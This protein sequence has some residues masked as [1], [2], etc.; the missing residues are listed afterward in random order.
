MTFPNIFSKEV[1]D[2]IIN[3]INILTPQSEPS[4]GKM[5]VSQMLA[6]CCV[7]YETI[8]TDKY[9]RPNRVTRFILKLMA[10]K[11]VVEPKP[12]PKNGRTAPHF[13]ISDERDFENEKAK[14]IAYITK[15]QQ[16]G[17][18]HYDGLDSH[19]FGVMTVDEWNSLFYKHMDHHLRQFGV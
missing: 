7:T 17:E 1:T 15:T 13:V 3:R 11:V 9:P 2:E 10:K 6:H 19:S 14:L 12:Y 18:S 5:N 8:Y 16:L 4:W